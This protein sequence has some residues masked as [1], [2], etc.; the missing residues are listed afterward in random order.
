MPTR[1]CAAGRSC[2]SSGRTLADPK[3]SGD[4][5]LMDAVEAKTVSAWLARAEWARRNTGSTGMV[6]GWDGPN[7][8]FGLLGLAL[9]EQGGD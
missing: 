5:K 7:R 2:P 6:K 4:V 3:Q 8:E 1:P 9:G